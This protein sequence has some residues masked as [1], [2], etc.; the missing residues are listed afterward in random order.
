MTVLEAINKRQSVRAYED[1]PVEPEKL[2]KILEAGRMA[3]SA[4]NSQAWKFIAVTDKALMPAL[5]DACNGQK[6]VG[7]A[8]AALAVCAT[9]QRT[10]ACG[11]PAHT[12]DCAIALS[13]MMLEAAELGLGTCWLGSFNAGKVKKVLGVPEDCQV[14]AVTPLGYAKGETP[15]RGRKSLEEVTAMN[16]WQ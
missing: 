14:V 8:P 4:N 7:E 15:F 6:F 13:F 11:Q 3:P 16:G 2:E 12:I 9:N 1:I 5:M 10:M